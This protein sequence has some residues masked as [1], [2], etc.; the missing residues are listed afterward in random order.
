MKYEKILKHL[1]KQGFLKTSREPE[2]PLSR[3][4]KTALIRRGNELFNKGDIEK[5]KR[6]FLTTHYTD[7]IIRIG[8]HYFQKKQV[9]EAFRMYKLAPAP[10]KTENMIEKMAAVLQYWLKDGDTNDT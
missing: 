9:F 8:D 10:D 1:P 7:G 6:I 3:E 2:P 5:A 4:Q